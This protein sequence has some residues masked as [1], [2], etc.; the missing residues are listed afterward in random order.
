MKPLYFKRLNILDNY[1]N[2]ELL[3]RCIFLFF[4]SARPH[5]CPGTHRSLRLIV[6]R[7]FLLLYL[8]RV[9]NAI[10]HSSHVLLLYAA[11][12]TLRKFLICS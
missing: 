10:W 5:K 11:L 2:Y 3:V 9:E 7:I 12:L 4:S 1:Y 6:Q 8:S